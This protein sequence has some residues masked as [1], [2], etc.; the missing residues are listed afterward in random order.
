MTKVSICFFLLHG[1][2]AVFLF[3]FIFC[4]AP[5]PV[6]LDPVKVWKADIDY[7]LCLETLSVLK[8]H[9]CR[10]FCTEAFIILLLH[11]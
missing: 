8:T 3:L 1:F 7:H 2:L 4:I 9:I 6:N 10:Y 11:S 5:P